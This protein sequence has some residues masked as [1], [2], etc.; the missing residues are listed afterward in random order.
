MPSAFR[1]RLWRL[2]PRG[3]RGGG[4]GL[5]RA[6]LATGAVVILLCASAPGRAGDTEAG[7][8]EEV[9]A[10]YERFN[11]H[12]KQLDLAEPMALLD[13]G[14]V[15]R[16]R[17]GL[18]RI[19]TE[20]LKS[21]YTEDLNATNDACH[22]HLNCRLSNLIFLGLITMATYEVLALEPL[23]G[24]SVKL[25]VLGRN[26]SGDEIKLVQE[27][28]QEDGRWKI[29]RSMKVPLNWGLTPPR[30]TGRDPLSE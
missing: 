20:S 3:R 1:F 26:T 11:A 18:K 17:R 6:G 2:L 30:R 13:A 25:T 24:G 22:A 15:S 23:D 4:G 10:A 29:A 5:M 9:F 28:L 14:R 12:L 7:D 8:T 19:E 16:A 21:F 27:W